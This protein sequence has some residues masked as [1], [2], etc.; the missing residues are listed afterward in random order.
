VSMQGEHGVNDV[1]IVSAARTAVGAFLGTLSQVPAPRLGAVAIKEALARA[2]LAPELVEQTFMG[3]VLTAGLGQAPARQAAI[4]AGLL[5]HTP[6]T[7]IGKVCGSGLE[8]VIAGARAIALGDASLVV[9]GGMESMSLAPYVLPKART[10]QRLGHGEIID[11]M[12]IDGLFDPYGHFH[13]AQAAERCAATLGI[14][15][16]EQ[17]AFARQSYERAR[18]A[19]RDGQFAAELA[20]VSVTAAK[21]K[22]E[23]V[24]ED[25]EPA[26][27]DLDKLP[28]LKPAFVADGT[29][30]AGNASKI[31]DGAAAVLLA[32]EAAV[33]THGLTPL[34]RIVSYAHHAQAPD[35]FPT[36]PVHAIEKVLTRAKL[37]RDDIGLYEINEAFAVV[38][39]ACTRLAKLDPARVNVNGGAVALGHPIGASGARI[40]TTLLYA[41]RARAVNRGLATLCIGG[42]E[43]NALIVERL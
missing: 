32:S 6:A 25:E 37:A 11:S 24:T 12:I 5:P 35:E 9:A 39:L 22:T 26:R 1:F 7:T 13:M 30:T 21:G 40:L 2:G 10:G 18:A 20:T 16:A 31:N 14:T 43:A 28:S 3:C 42:G 19:Q 17:D 33:K 8:A 23:L 4:Y 34:A 15:R 29:I 41:M 38:G 36:A 27:G